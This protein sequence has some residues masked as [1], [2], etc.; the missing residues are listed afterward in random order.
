[1]RLVRAVDPAVSVSP[2][3][4]AVAPGALEVAP[5]TRLP[6]TE[7]DA[8]PRLLTQPVAW[9]SL[10]FSAERVLPSAD[11]PA[12]R[13]RLCAPIRRPGK[14]IAIGLNYLD[15]TAETGLAPPEE[16]VTF[17]KYPTS[18]IGSGE[19][20]L[21][22]AAVTAD[23]D[24]EAE[25]AVVVGRRCGPGERGTLDHVAAYTAANDVSARD[26]QFRDRQWTRAKSIDTF[27]PL[28]PVLVTPDEFGNPQDKR[29]WTTVN[30]RIMQ[31]ASTADMVFDVAYL[32]DFLTATVTLEPGDVVLTG[33]PPG[34]G[35]FRTPPVFLRDGD[36]VTVGVEG[37]GEL[38]N[39]VRLA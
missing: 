10:L 37:T 16:P 21:I 33:T 15:H 12:S 39:P 34:V 29:I 36:L 1:M 14:I 24:W 31:D 8:V 7:G 5:A 25:L 23:V 4:Y 20:I 28:G 32:M 3:L 2:A 18:V 17:A 13:L 11:V 6:G 22:P 38:T 9:A 30:G 35:G 26:L 19:P 27:C